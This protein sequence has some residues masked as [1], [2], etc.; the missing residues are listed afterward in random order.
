VEEAP[1]PQGSSDVDTIKRMTVV[2]TRDPRVLGNALTLLVDAERDV[3][4]QT[5]VARE[6]AAVLRDLAAGSAANAEVPPPHTHTHTRASYSFFVR[7]RYNTLKCT[8]YRVIVYLFT[9]Q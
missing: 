6:I 5:V 8:F 4:K 2:L 1:P 7:K 9:L 3:P